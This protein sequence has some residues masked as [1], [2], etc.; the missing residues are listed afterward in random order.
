[1]GSSYEGVSLMDFYRFGLRTMSHNERLSMINGLLNKRN[2]RPL[3]GL[4]NNDEGQPEIVDIHSWSD[5]N[6]RFFQDV[7]FV[8]QPPNDGTPYNHMVRFNA[9]GDVSDGAVFI[10]VINGLVVV[11]RQ[12]RTSLGKET[13][14]L[15]RGFCDNVDRVAKQ[16]GN[17]GSLSLGDLPK[18]LVRELGEEV[19]S[20]GGAKI[21]SLTDLGQ[22]Y[23]NT[24]THNVA[25]DMYIVAMTVEKG[26]L[27]RQL[28]G[29]ENL[30]V[31]LLTWPEL[32]ME[33]RCGE[34]KD[35]H[36]LA[37]LYRAWLYRLNTGG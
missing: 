28:G 34:I 30:R 21:T 26:M 20:G 2:L 3:G 31:K 18:V 7:F 9:N 6:A 11:V 29:S 36:S 1:V 32:E 8:V 12:F 13:W 33:A 17:P 37:A 23:E 25:P 24:G 15:P 5:E 4:G 16:G 14:E 10:P 19:L 22:V 27:E 35:M